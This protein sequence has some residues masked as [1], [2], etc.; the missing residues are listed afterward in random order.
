MQSSRTGLVCRAPNRFTPSTALWQHFVAPTHQHRRFSAPVEA[1]HP[2]SDANAAS[3][4]ELVKPPGQSHV[5]PSEGKT[6]AS[7]LSKHQ[8]Q[9]TKPRLTIRRLETDKGVYHDDKR[10]ASIV[11]NQ[12]ALHK[13]RLD[14]L[15]KPEAL[16]GIARAAFDARGDYKGV[17]VE[18]M[19]NP[20][21]VRES[22][23]PWC[24]SPEERESLPAMDRL[25]AEIDR[26]CTYARPNHYDKIARNRVIDRVR[27]DAL[28][29]LPNFTLEVF[30]SERTGTALATSD[31]DLRLVNPEKVSDPA[32]ANRP[33][34]PKARTKA[35][36]TLHKLHQHFKNLNKSYV[37]ALIRHARY[38]LISLQDRRTGLDVQIVLSND[39]SESRR[40]MQHYLEVYP[41]LLP[42]FTVVKT[43]FDI[44][45][46]SD[47]FRGGFGSYSLFMMIVAS[48]QQ[49]P[50]PRNDAAGALLNFLKFYR[51]FD[52]TKQGISVEPA[53]LF[54]KDAEILS[55]MTPKT[56]SKIQEGEAKPLPPYM[57]LLR[58]PADP[59][60]DLGRKGIAIKHVQAT[61]QSILRRLEHDLQV[62]TRPTFLGPLVGPAY[63]L[64]YARRERL[65]AQGKRMMSETH[66]ELADLAK[67]VRED[68]WKTGST[69]AAG[70]SGKVV[71]ENTSE[72]VMDGTAVGGGAVETADTPKAES[73]TAVT[74]SVDD[75]TAIT[76]MGTNE[77]AAAPKAESETAI[78][79][80]GAIETVVAEA[81]VSKA[82]AEQ[83]PVAKAT[84]GE[85]IVDTAGQGTQEAKEQ[86]P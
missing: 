3:N 51:D 71:E 69:T 21:P 22:A 18:P 54:D 37:L 46:L 7:N 40:I 70:G 56:R 85:E 58:D 61:F 82:V 49:N 15:K 1:I 80:K 12:Q 79:D 52:T 33:P 23:L 32:Q 25:V 2:K 27:R 66:T 14:S 19:V 68:G 78:T 62:K 63:M 77:M 29:G 57:L 75:E 31:I 24:L 83:Q 59:T 84:G 67:A 50:H 53:E 38:P 73:E 47:V 86:T 48:I 65:A 81:T 72:A 9:Q 64:N 6:G 74:R 36:R 42:L 41:Y 45:G 5:L 34:P 8:P 13:V 4:A 26:F 35:L 17:I 11:K 10:T 39:T 60:N 55:I 76:D 44:R 16:L 20:K 30:G 43:I 28:K